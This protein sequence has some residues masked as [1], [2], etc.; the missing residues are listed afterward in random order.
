MILSSL[1]ELANEDEGCSGVVGKT[2]AEGKEYS[3]PVRDSASF[4][5]KDSFFACKQR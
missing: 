5:N 3:V 4:V 1:D 2:M